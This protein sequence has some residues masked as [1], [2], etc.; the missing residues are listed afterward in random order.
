M[1]SKDRFLKIK[2]R[3]GDCPDLKFRNIRIG[4]KNSVVFFLESTS[5]GSTISQFIIDDIKYNNH[6]GNFIIYIYEGNRRV[7]SF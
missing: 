3:L 4:K 1:N 6:F 2:E 5:N 7:G